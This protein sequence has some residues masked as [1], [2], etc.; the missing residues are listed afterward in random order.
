MEKSSP[1]SRTMLC[2]KFQTLLGW[3]TYPSSS[4]GFHYVYKG[5]TKVSIR[6]IIFNLNHLKMV[7]W[8]YTCWI[9]QCPF[10]GCS[11]HFSQC[12]LPSIVWRCIEWEVGWNGL[13]P[14]HYTCFSLSP[15]NNFYHKHD[16]QVLNDIMNYKSN[17]KTL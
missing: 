6:A 1:G 2:R 9:Y 4:I 14:L 7:T 12:T 5:K 17:Q 8:M 13:S 3:W 16:K 11:N 10:F 15:L